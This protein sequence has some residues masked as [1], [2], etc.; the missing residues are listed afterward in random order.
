MW[1]YKYLSSP[2]GTWS[3]SKLYCANNEQHQHAKLTGYHA[4]SHR[5]WRHR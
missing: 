1:Y 3:L 5:A 2:S 4:S